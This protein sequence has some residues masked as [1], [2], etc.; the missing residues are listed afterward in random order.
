MDFQFSGEE[1]VLRE[2][3]A[4]FVNDR[5]SGAARGW[6][7]DQHFPIEIV[8]DLAELGLLG[9]MVDP[10]YGG[11]GLGAS[12]M[13]IVVEEMAKGDG[14]LALTLAS[15]NGL[16]SS[17]IR[18][19]GSDEQKDKFLR[20]LAC[21]EKLG[22]WGLT[23]PGSGSDAAAMRTN[24]LK[25]GDDWVL[26][27]SKIFITQGNVGG[28]FVILAVTD[29]TKGTKGISAFILDPDMPG[30]GRQPMKDKLGMRSSDTAE[31]SFENVRVCDSRRL[32]ELNQ[33]FINTLQIL[34]RGR[35]TIGALAL[36]LAGA[37]LQHSIDYAK[38]R[39]QFKKPIANFQA[40]QWKLANMATEIEAAKL[41]VY[42]SAWLCDQGKTFSLEASMAKLFASET[43]MRA[44]DEA[45]QIHGGY[46]YTSEFPVERHLRDAKLCTIGEGTSEIQRLVIARRLLSNQLN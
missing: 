18:L 28:V 21:G 8:P 5:V 33:G 29:K 35:I 20:P 16:C 15:H 2:S 45:I 42:R 9:V 34:D 4:R 1:V 32:G 3:V 14:S 7:R 40:I 38:V 26:N 37:A 31:L 12:A 25:D 43:A 46:G 19:F 22:A 39:V 41:L 27:G 30:F 17:H 24:A 11:S 6:D 23:E 44:T 36:G 13:A 10:E